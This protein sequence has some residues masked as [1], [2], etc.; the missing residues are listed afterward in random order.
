MPGTGRIPWNE[1]KVALD[2][3]NFDGP[4]VM[5]PFLMTGGQVGRDIGIW[6]EVIENPNLDELARE[7]A[8]FV[9]KNLV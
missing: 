5:E 8:A 1:I 3:V 9:K 4:L 7:S 2:D 6:R